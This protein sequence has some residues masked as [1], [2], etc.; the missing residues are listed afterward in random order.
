MNN[1]EITAGL[2]RYR[3]T[4]L[5][6]VAAT[7]SLPATAI[8]AD[9][10]LGLESEYSDNSGLSATDENDDL[11]TSLLAGFAISEEGPKLNADITSLIE[12]N[13]YRD[14][15]FNDETW[16]YLNGGLSWTLRPRTLYWTAENFYSQVQ[17][18]PLEPGTPDNLVNTNVFSTGPN[19]LFRIDQVN[20]I[21]MEARYMDYRFDG[22][23]ADNVRN[24]LSASWV[25]GPRP[26]TEL[27]LT[28][29]FEDVTY[30]ETNDS[31]YQRT[32][33][34]FGLE[35]E[36]SRSLFELDL[37]VSYIDRQLGENIDGF[38]GR[39]LWRN[40]FRQQS[41]FQLDASTQF[42]DSARDLLLASDQQQQIGVIQEQ[43]SGDIF[44]DRRLEATYRLGS[45]INS[46]EMYLAYRDEDYEILLLDRITKTIRFNYENV[47]SSTL[48]ISSYLQYREVEYIDAIQQD[49][50]FNGSIALDYRLTRKYTL[51]L[52]YYR[53]SQDSTNPIYQ[54]DENRIMLSFFYGTNPRYYRY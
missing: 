38:L 28:S 39:L 36:Y 4:I 2:S 22:T 54:Y 5:L 29:E 19:I 35:T 13:S 53:N 37:G 31:D 26:S 47:Q 14:E 40:Q 6:L 24:S 9:Y 34:F 42:T 21:R 43:I 25:Y 32:N 20:S 8:R 18:D 11:R 10:S 15:T 27:S 51:R 12:Y 52:A 48:S 41:Y 30:D 44:Y 33:L 16:L 7:I 49:D 45:S 3:A 17:S 46:Y 50:E 23:D 1:M